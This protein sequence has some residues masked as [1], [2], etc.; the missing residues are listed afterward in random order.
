MGQSDHAERNQYIQ[1]YANKIKADMG[2]QNA[3]I[4]KV[5]IKTYESKDELLSKLPSFLE[6]VAKFNPVTEKAIVQHK[7]PENL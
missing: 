2:T 3:K 1:D 7:L 5:V 4:G 6:S